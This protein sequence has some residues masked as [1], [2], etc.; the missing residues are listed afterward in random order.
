MNFITIAIMVLVGAPIAFISFII[1]T[2][3]KMSI[4]YERVKVVNQDDDIQIQDL[5]ENTRSRVKEGKAYS[6][7]SGLGLTNPE[8]T[9]QLN[10]NE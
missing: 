8:Q 3:I 7:D 4:V 6:K 9:L 5:E 10:H 2:L 1:Y